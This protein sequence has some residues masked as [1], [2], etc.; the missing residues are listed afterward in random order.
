LLWTRGGT[1]IGTGEMA[2]DAGTI[3]GYMSSGIPLGLFG[4]RSIFWLNVR[5]GL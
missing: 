4:W 2:V 5:V 3:L 1:A